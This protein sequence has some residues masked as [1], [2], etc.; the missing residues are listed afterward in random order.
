M[1]T[2]HNNPTP[3]E[4]ACLDA[5]SQL[6]PGIDRQAVLR[7]IRRFYDARDYEEV[8]ETHNPIRHHTRGYLEQGLAVEC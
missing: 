4:A 3:A 2:Q 7:V 8:Q 6:A 1:N 5:L